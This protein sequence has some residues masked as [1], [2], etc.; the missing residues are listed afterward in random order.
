MINRPPAFKGLNMRIPSI[1][2][3]TKGRGFMNHRSGL[4]GD[5]DNKNNNRRFLEYDGSE[6]Q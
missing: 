1:I 5:R 4:T 6:Q 3:P 2:I